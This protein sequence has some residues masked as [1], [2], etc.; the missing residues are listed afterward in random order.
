VLVANNTPGT[1]T[2]PPVMLPD[3]LMVPEDI[4]TPDASK[5][6]PVMLPD[7]DKVTAV[8]LIKVPKVLTVTL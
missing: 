4:N 2:L 8:V 7:A 3:A 6:P 1:N 5:F